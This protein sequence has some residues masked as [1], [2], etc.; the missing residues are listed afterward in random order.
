MKKNL[1]FISV[2]LVIGQLVHAQQQ[3][4]TWLYSGIRITPYGSPLSNS[5][6]LYDSTQTGEYYWQKSKNQKTAAWAMLGGGVALSIIGI[7]GFTANYDVL[8]EGGPAETYALLT[9]VGAG[10]SLGSIPLFI[11]SG[12][13][14]RK[15]AS[16]SVKSQHI[17]IPQQNGLAFKSQPAVSLVIP[18]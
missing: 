13:N 14:H 9:F 1:L 16:L 11:A 10:L 5:V 8:V 3:T 15:A 17:F 12:R 6:V 18:L 7:V 2:A 4:N